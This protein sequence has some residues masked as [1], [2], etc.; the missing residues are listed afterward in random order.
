MFEKYYKQHL[1]K[2]LLHGRSTSE[3]SG[4]ALGRCVLCCSVVWRHVLW[5]H[6]LCCG[7]LRRAVHR[8]L[9][10]AQCC[11]ATPCTCTVCRCLAMADSCLAC[12]SPPS[13]PS[14][15]LARAQSSCC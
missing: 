8:L 15:L 10:A 13:L 11:V 5:R 3:D 9:C 1:A 2:R 7:V 12:A 6:V 4:A 14:P